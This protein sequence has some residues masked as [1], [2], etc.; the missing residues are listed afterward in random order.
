MYEIHSGIK[1]SRP[2]LAVVLCAGVLAATLGIAA[3]QVRD[4][5][6]LGKPRT[7]GE[8]ALSVRLPRDWVE[9]PLRPGSF[10]MK[11]R[12]GRGAGDRPTV[13]RRI[14]IDTGRWPAFISPEVWLASTL[15]QPNRLDVRAR[16]ISST[17]IGPLF[18]QQAIHAVQHGPGRGYIQEF[19]TRV[20]VSPRG[21]Y[22]AVHYEP[23]FEMTP[24]ERQ[25]LDSICDTIRLDEPALHTSR[26]QVLEA[27]GLKFSV[28][29]D[30]QLCGPDFPEAP[31]LYIAQLSDGHPIWAI[32]VLRTWLAPDREVG[33][34]L[35]DF[36]REVWG[37]SDRDITIQRSVS[38]R[39]RVT[40]GVRHPRAETGIADITSVWATADG[41]SEAAILFVSAPADRIQ[42]ADEACVQLASQLEFTAPYPRQWSLRAAV[43][44]GAALA[45][46]VQAEGPK[47]AWAGQRVD[48]FY[49]CTMSVSMSLKTAVY[50]G[51]GPRSAGA[52][53]GYAG[54]MVYYSGRHD[55]GYVWSLDQDLRGH[56]YRFEGLRGPRNDIPVSVTEIR[57]GSSPVLRREITAAP[58]RRGSEK[59]IVYEVPIRNGFVCLP[60]LDVAERWTATGSGDPLRI[61]AASS[62][63][64][65]KLHTQLMRRI[66]ADAEGRSRVMI[67]RDYYPRGTIIAYASDGETAYQIAPDRRY[68]RSTRQEVAKISKRAA[69][70]LR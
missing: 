23:L 24:G 48:E 38:N 40:V 46:R 63:F 16:V 52:G 47:P 18:G 60:L 32:G 56:A 13:D 42:A 39:G 5:L 10:V 37:L 70:D 31:G 27:A 9:D 62:L 7:L 54:R 58:R 35:A 43:D 19:C 49:V 41:E 22:I 59:T 36:A 65:D 17:R 68:E 4:K 25:L 53:G 33:D 67:Q 6:A 45:E 1:P 34:L 26:A 66:P 3:F 44:A 51:R 30:W 64:G 15:R 55:S 8:S 12:R 21:D 69:Q 57:D 20:V 11:T 61:V 2:T 50:I 28:P 29:P 14:T